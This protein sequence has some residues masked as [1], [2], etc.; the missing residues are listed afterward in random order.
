MSEK[1]NGGDEFTRL[2]LK[3]RGNTPWQFIKREGT[4]YHFFHN[5][6][7]ETIIIDAYSSVIEKFSRNRPEHLG[8]TDEEIES[9]R[10][11]PKE[12]KALWAQ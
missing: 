10:N 1:I 3:G 5:K 11:P 9:I 2:V 7:Q 8:L 4:E 12:G 6:R